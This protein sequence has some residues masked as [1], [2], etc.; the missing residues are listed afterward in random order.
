[1]GCGGC[2]RGEEGKE[3]RGGEGKGGY[4]GEGREGEGRGGGRVGDLLLQ[5]ERE[6]ERGG[7]MTVALGVC[8]KKD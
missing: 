4:V 6:R 7:R 5:R 2:R 3:G 8:R 1:M